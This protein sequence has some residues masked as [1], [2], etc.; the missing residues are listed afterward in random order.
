M[1]DVE[2]IDVEDVDVEDVDV[3]DVE[4]RLWNSETCTYSI[5]WILAEKLLYCYDYTV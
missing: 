2:D 1:L 5:C 3:E 4:G